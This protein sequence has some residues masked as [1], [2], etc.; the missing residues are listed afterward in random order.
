M[1]VNEKSKPL[2]AIGLLVD[3]LYLLYI[4]L[5]EYNHHATV[6]FTIDK[7]SL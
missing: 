6:F 7:Q 4:L 1:L 3:V 5:E 2:K